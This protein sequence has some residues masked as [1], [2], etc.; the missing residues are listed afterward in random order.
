MICLT[1]VV[2]EMQSF[3][4]GAADA[5]ALQLSGLLVDMLI[6]DTMAR[7]VP[8]FRSGRGR[9]QHGNVSQALDP[10][11][12]IRVELTPDLLFDGKYEAQVCQTIPAFKTSDPHVVGNQRRIA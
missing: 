4:G 6:A 8:R 12:F 1:M 9:D 5:V 11:C 2:P 7:S 3:R 10:N